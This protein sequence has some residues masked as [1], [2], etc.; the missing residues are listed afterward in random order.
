M[1]TV[2]QKL[3]LYQSLVPSAATMDRIG[4]LQLKAILSLKYASIRHPCPSIQPPS[5]N[6][7]LSVKTTK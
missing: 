1:P 4:Q 2:T 7:T 6:T 5:V 3:I